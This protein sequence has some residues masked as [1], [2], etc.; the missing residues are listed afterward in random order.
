MKLFCL[1]TVVVLAGGAALPAHAQSTN[2]AKVADATK[3]D[4]SAEFQARFDACLAGLRDNAAAAGIT[5]AT[6]AAN[7]RDLV[8][9]PSVLELLNRQPEFN[10]PIWDYLAGLVDDERV[11]DGRAM[12][13]EHADTLA[14]VQK[15]YGVDPETVVAVWGVESDYGKTFGKRP[16]LVSL[17]TLSCFDRRQSFFRGELFSTLQIIQSGDIDADALRGSWAGAFGHTQFMP[18]TFQ[19]IAVDFD[20]D[21]RRDLIGS[22][23]DALASTAHY[24]DRAGWRSGES[25]G[26]EV[27]LPSGFD[28]E[29]TGRKNRKPLSSWLQRGV[30]RADGEPIDLP[31]DTRA[32]MLL[33]AGIKGPAFL[34]FRNFDAIYSYNASESYALAI[35]HL[36]DRLRGAGDFVTPWPTDDPG[37]SRKQRRE[38]QTL[39]L[40]RGHDIGEVDGMIGSRT[41]AAI[42]LEQQRLGRSVDGRA[43]S[44]ILE[45]LRGEAV[46]ERDD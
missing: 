23:P 32:A 45:A 31:S 21:G 11:A 37:L 27:V 44:R 40:A 8:P 17:A 41:R 12:L 38:L 33:P 28:A 46:L 39:L 4:V 13:A 16:L 24:L 22:I 19:R 9:D 43:G 18:S 20:G 35:A 34:V 1:M 26:F 25:W 14:R 5:A 7:T 30:K 15:V 29:A 3:P 6:F 10:T 42:K 36:S 2:Q